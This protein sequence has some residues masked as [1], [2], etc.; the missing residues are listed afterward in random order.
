MSPDPRSEWLNL[1]Y[2]EWHWQTTYSTSSSLQ[3][4]CWTG[5]PC[6]MKG[7][8]LKNFKRI[9][10]HVFFVS[11][12]DFVVRNEVIPRPCFVYCHWVCA[13]PALHSSGL[14]IPFFTAVEV[15]SPHFR[16]AAFHLW[17]LVVWSLLRILLSAHLSTKHEGQNLR[18]GGQVSPM[19]IS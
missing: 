14:A 10:S 19:I 17:K 11:C 2:G 7:T 18:P 4:V 13:K 15:T 6:N 3:S 16:R 12:H 1:H 8:M 5:F 9:H